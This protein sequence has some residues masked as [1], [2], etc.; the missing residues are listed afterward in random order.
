MRYTI[1][2]KD[3][4]FLTACSSSPIAE[5]LLHTSLFS[6]SGEIEPEQISRCLKMLK[7]HRKRVVLVW[8]LL[9]KDSTL[10]E[11]GGEI[12]NWLDRIDAVLFQDL[13]VGSY[14]IE[15]Y[16]LLKLQLS[17]EK[18]CL[19]QTGIC[20]WANYFTPHLERLILSNQLPLA[21]V[22]GICSSCQ[23][24][25]GLPGLGRIET[26]ST[27]RLLVQPHFPTLH[28]QQLLAVSEDRP[29]QYSPLIEN[30][31]GTFMYYDK[32]LFVL[33]L[34]E[35]IEEVGVQYLQL[36]FPELVDLQRFNR[37]YPYPDWI[38]KLKR[39]WSKNTTRGFL[40]V[41]KTHLPLQRLS[42]RYLQKERE[43]QIGVVLESVKKVHLLVELGRSIQLPVKIAFHTP[44]GRRVDYEIKWA[45]DLHGRREMGKLGEG[46]YLFPWVK[47]VVPATI[48]K[49]L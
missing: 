45:Q 40:R 15:N 19:N 26:F 48:L 30:Q 13:G 3:L 29:H 9:C 17:L 41:N 33:D 24:G 32:D 6:R 38:P 23:V 2:L 12:K 11:L 47:Y 28:S 8:D 4:T 18:G 37:L 39:E 43:H 5:I 31:H 35:E 16:P 10:N 42:N 44:E 21:Q 34:L 49:A 1:S 14:L 27:P 25:V 22:K 46:Y 20:A 7:K 36:D